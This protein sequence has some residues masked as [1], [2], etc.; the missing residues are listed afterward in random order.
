[1]NKKLFFP[2]VFLVT[3]ISLGLN[4]YLSQPV[5]SFHHDGKIIQLGWG[6]PPPTYIKEHIREMEQVPFDGLVLDLK[7]NHGPEDTGGYFSWNVWGSQVLS[8]DDYSQS[9]EALK[10]TDF[11]KFTD[12]FLRFNLSPANVSWYDDEFEAVLQNSQLLATIA[13]DSKLKGIFLDTEQYGNKPQIFNYQREQEKKSS[14]FRDYQQQVRKR[15]RELMESLNSVYPNITILLSY[16]YHR[17]YKGNAKSLETASYGLL[18]SF[19]DGMLEAA[20][21]NTLI[22]DGYEFSYFY[23]RERQFQRA[24][25]IIKDLGLERTAVPNEFQQHYKAGFGLWLDAGSHKRGWDI[26]DLSKN[27]FSPEEFENSVSFALKHSDGYVWI[28]SERAKWWQRNV[29]QPYIDSLKR[30]KNTI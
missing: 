1:M 21:A 5:A 11:N 17:A 9:I 19:L 12:N 29:P 13:K 2:L 6:T 8:P 10:T 26:N 24:Y 16:G 20:N 15:G 18:P 27:Y 28:Y 4:H 30:A 7:S 3:L 22:V 25:S 23:K 14:S